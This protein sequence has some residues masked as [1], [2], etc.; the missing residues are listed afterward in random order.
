MKDWLAGLAPRERLMLLLGAA[1]LPVLLVYLWG[2]RPLAEEADRLRAANERQ[3]ETLAWMREAAGE[4]RALQRSAPRRAPAAGGSLLGQVD[5]L[6]R[7]AQVKDR[8]RRLQPEGEAMV[9]VEI[10]ATDFN[11]LIGW[12]DRLQKQGVETTS[13]SLTRVEDTNEADARLTLERPE[14]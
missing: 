14:P 7:Q 13:L 5:R 10:E 8:I 2:W 9:R 11:R 4:V 6:A 1:A 12:L 3:R